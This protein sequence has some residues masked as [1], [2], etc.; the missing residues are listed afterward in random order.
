M[1]RF[2]VFSFS[3]LFFSFVSMVHAQT[4]V[5]GSATADQKAQ[6][7]NADAQ[8]E[9]Q[10][11]K[12][13]RANGDT[14]AAQAATDQINVDNADAQLQEAITADNQ[15]RTSGGSTTAIAAADAKVNDMGVQYW[16]AKYTQ[17]TNKGDTAAAAID[18]QNEQK[19]A[20]GAYQNAK[21]AGASQQQ[22][23]QIQ[24]V[25]PSVAGNT[26]SGSGNFVPLTN[27]PIF[28]DSSI[29]TNA[30]GLSAF[31]NALYKYCIGI[32]ATLAVLQIMRA[33]IMYMGGDSVTETKD[34]R[35]LIGTAIAGL[36]LIL[37][38]VVVFSII[39]PKILS[40][41]LGTDLSNLKSDPAVSGSASA[42]TG[43]QAAVTASSAQDCTSKGG[44]VIGDA[45]GSSVTCQVP[46]SSQ[47]AQD[48]LACT[49]Y[50]NIEPD[51]KGSSCSQLAGEGYQGVPS[52]CCQSLDANMQCCAELK[53]NL[54]SGS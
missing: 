9:L 21:T 33:G 43:P 23:Q 54:P 47:A 29:V 41:N 49:N 28:N 2:F 40:L 31:F 7:D 42:S 44:T 17:D 51:P 37:S 14:A 25:L 52:G 22:L 5:Q 15:L 38:P 20:G 24:Q 50:T 4:A 16:K 11:E 48:S 45:S 46:A 53:S 30:Q 39:N 10:I 13:A 35:R 1:K 27:L 12:T 26:T 32:A 3:L 8:K 19:D 36:V 34:A 18:A 6:Q